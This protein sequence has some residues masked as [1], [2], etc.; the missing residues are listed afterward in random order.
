MLPA[1][2]KNL[3]CFIRYIR[4]LSIVRTIWTYM[5][6]MQKGRQTDKFT[7]CS[8]TIRIGY[9]HDK[10]CVIL[11][12]IYQLCSSFPPDTGSGWWPRA[13]A[14]IPPCAAQEASSRGNMGQQCTIFAFA[15]EEINILCNCLLLSLT[16]EFLWDLLFAR[17]VAWSLLC[18]VGE[19]WAS[20]EC[21]TPHRPGC[22]H[23]VT[24]SPCM[25]LTQTT[26]PPVTW[27]CHADV[28]N[29]SVSE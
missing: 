12:I 25:T 16:L 28:T 26:S 29:V 21:L 24:A 10:V 11:F 1:W 19:A 5:W 4:L 22:S 9:K 23:L 14:W 18:R 7:K 8:S 27:H 17:L 20:A 6:C 2:Q 3:T 15:V 13:G